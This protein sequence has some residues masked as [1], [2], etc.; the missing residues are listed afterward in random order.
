M[1]WNIWRVDQD[2]ANNFAQCCPIRRLVTTMGVSLHFFH[3]FSYFS[4]LSPTHLNFFISHH[5]PSAETPL[6]LPF[7]PAFQTVKTHRKR[8]LRS[9]K[10][11][12]FRA[13]LKE[14]D[15]FNQKDSPMT[16]DRPYYKSARSYGPLNLVSKGDVPW[17]DWR[18]WF[19]RLTRLRLTR[20][21]H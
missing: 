7:F 6:G 16:T 21:S 8:Y 13:T 18:S 5:N 11:S 14:I 10:V 12:S 15:D 4:A 17:A 9:M 20:P 2:L 1:A 3:S 19:H